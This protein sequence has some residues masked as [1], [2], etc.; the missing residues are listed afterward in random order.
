M[1]LCERRRSAL[2][3]FIVQRSPQCHSS[4]FVCLLSRISF[5]FSS[6]SP[7]F[8]SGHSGTSG[9]AVPFLSSGYVLADFPTSKYS[10]NASTCSRVFRYFFVHYPPPRIYSGYPCV[11]TKLLLALLSKKIKI[12][13]KIFAQSKI[14]HYLCNWKLHCITRCITKGYSKNTSQSYWQNKT[15]WL[16]SNRP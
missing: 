9:I 14:I 4:P 2:S 5:E 1:Y 3:L 15:Y 13:L 8:P 11:L 6:F 12:F 10:S 7:P 16:G